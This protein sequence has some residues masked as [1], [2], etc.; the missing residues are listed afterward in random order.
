VR[1][2]LARTAA[3]GVACLCAAVGWGRPAA[4]AGFATARFGGEHGS[5]VTTNPMALYYNPA[6]IGFSEGLH[7]M[8]D[9][10]LALRNANASHLRAPTDPPDPPGGEGANTGNAHLFNVF[11]APAFGATYRLGPFAFGA[12]LFIPFGGQESF[13][14]NRRFVGSPFYLAADG[15]QRWHV[16]NA[17]QFYLYGTLGAAYRVGP[18]S[19]GVT[20]NLVRSSVSLLR[21]LIPLS[22]PDTA[23]EGRGQLDVAGT[24]GSLGVGVMVEP[25]KGRLWIGA[26]YQSQPGF[27]PQTLNGTL[28]LSTPYANPPVTQTRNVAFTQALPDI[29]RLGVRWRARGD[30]ELRLLGDF[31]RWSVMRTQCLSDQGQPCAVLAD[32]STAPGASVLV[33]LR[34]MWNDTYHAHLGASFW[35]KPEIELF[36]GTGVENAA[37]PD[38]TLEPSVMDAFTIEGAVGTRIFI[39]HWI[40]LAVSYTHLQL[41]NRDNTG[42]SEL[43]NAAQPTRQQDAGGQYNQFVGIIDLSLEK[44]F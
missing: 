15:I 2:A 34:R 38:A 10:N 35:L 27:G 18:F 17:R 14:Q 43:Y 1:R 42:K 28:Q 29:V 9:G 39:A 37:V 12:G 8:L 31:T 33:N 19:V 20:G 22:D 5:V 36:A 13:D 7:L 16:I 6:G 44:T 3:A 30:L 25:V 21:A 4:A 40:H 24:T 32:G 41:L 11:G 26:S 23:Q